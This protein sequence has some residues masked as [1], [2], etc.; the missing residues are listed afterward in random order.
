MRASTKKVIWFGV[1]ILAFGCIAAVRAQEKNQVLGGGSL[2]ALTAEVRQLRLAV[3]DS[4][5]SQTQTQALGV[6][7][8]AQQSRIVQVA[9]RLDVVRRELDGA[10][11]ASRS[12][13][14]R[15]A[16][17]EERLSQVTDPK[18]RL[19]LEDQS[20]AMNLEQK[21][22]SLHEQQA[23]NRETELSQ[24]LQLENDRWADL[25]SRLEQLI[26]R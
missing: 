22:L 15:L 6:Y 12:I 11:L 13:A 7:L 17:T 23:R 2:T 18:E 14:T 19:A 9:S 4:I 21:T 26:K 1:T 8:S 16:R 5:R 3:K 25:I 10:S 20:R 24:A